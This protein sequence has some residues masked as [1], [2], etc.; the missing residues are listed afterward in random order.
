MTF[1]FEEPKSERKPAFHKTTKPDLDKLL[2]GLLDGLIGIAYEDDSQ[3]CV[4][5]CRE[6]FGSPSRLEL[7]IK[8]VSEAVPKTSKTHTPQLFENT[9]PAGGEIAVLE[10]HDFGDAV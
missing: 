1:Y 6:I 2:R 4:S 8:T 7:E 3:V 9:E 5:E 10:T